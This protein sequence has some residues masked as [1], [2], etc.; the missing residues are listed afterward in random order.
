MAVKL[1]SYNLNGIRS[2]LK[3]GL[4]EWLAAH[5][6][7]VLCFQELKA[8]AEQVD[9]TPF[10]EMGYDHWWWHDAEKAGYSGVATFSRIEPRHVEVGMGDARF[11]AEGRVLRTDFDGWSLVN[12]YFPSG[13]TGDVRQ[14]VKYEFMDAF[15]D[16]AHALLE[17]QP[18]LV[19]TGDFNIAHTEMDIHDPVRNKK[20]SGFLPEE[21]A[22]LTKFL[23]SGFVDA[24]RYK[25]PDKVE[26]SWWSFR[27]N[28][29]AKNK[30]WRID[31]F[32][33]SEALKERVI[34]A[35]HYNEAVHSDHC[36]LFLILD[37]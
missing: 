37:V 34:D 14:Q 36:P 24:F 20:N 9:L 21:R 28:A 23:D 12:V 7:D 27:A 5:P 11:D 4:A 31:Y 33:V 15:Y 3:K 32:V 26:Y 10:R 8:R 1:L 17:V 18:R 35:G 29:R 30:G 25:H 19:I 13:T 16:Y 22:W 2:A 6:H